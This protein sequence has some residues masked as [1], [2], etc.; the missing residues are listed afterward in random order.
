MLSCGS[1]IAGGRECGVTFPKGMRVEMLQRSTFVLRM[2][3]MLY[4]TASTEYVMLPEIKADIP[5]L[6]VTHVQDSTT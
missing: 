6:S 1:V 3:D 5:Q 4:Y 2:L